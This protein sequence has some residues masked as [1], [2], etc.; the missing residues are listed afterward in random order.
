MENSKRY[1]VMAYDKDNDIF[2]LVGDI[3]PDVSTA[4]TV[5]K[6]FTLA[7]EEDY[8]CNHILEKQSNGQY[9]NKKEPF[10]W[11]EVWDNHQNQSCIW[12]AGEYVI[13]K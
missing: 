12:R 5:A 3:Y 13:S 1:A 9:E 7:V 11:I 6:A 4:I 2:K 10:D 8:L